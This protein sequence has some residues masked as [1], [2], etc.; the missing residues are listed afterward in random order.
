MTRIEKDFLLDFKKFDLF[1]FSSG[2]II[3][4][5]GIDRKHS[6]PLQR[7]IYCW[8]AADAKRRWKQKSIHAKRSDI[9]SIDADDDN[10]D[11][12]DDDRDA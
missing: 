3:T 5:H 1:S 9:V 2:Y 6:L 11:D 4:P 8:R 10:D 7:G 12:G